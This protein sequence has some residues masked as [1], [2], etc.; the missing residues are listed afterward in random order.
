LKRKNILNNLKRK[1]TKDITAEPA[2]FIRSQING[3]GR[4]NSN[5]YFQSGPDLGRATRAIA[6]GPPQKERTLQLR[7][8]E[9]NLSNY[10]C[11]VTPWSRRK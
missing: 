2:T 11:T 10:K 5:F 8:R 6:P 7:L 3:D 9:K 4:Q 1:V